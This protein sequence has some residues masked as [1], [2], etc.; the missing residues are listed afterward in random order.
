MEFL[1]RV[2]AG[3]GAGGILAALTFVSLLIGV[4]IHGMVIL[5]AGPVIDNYYRKKGE[6]V[7]EPGSA[8]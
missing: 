1:G 7:Y 6:D 4:L 5:M 2:F 3:I 8:K